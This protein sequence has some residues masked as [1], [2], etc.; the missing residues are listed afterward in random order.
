MPL[1]PG[2]VL[3]FSPA[4]TSGS[5]IATRA[6]ARRSK[7]YAPVAAAREIVAA[8]GDGSRQQLRQCRQGIL[9]RKLA[10][11][12]EHAGSVPGARNEAS[13]ERAWARWLAATQASPRHRR[14]LA[15]RASDQR[16]SLRRPVA[17]PAG[18]ARCPA[19][20]PATLP[21]ERR[22]A[23]PAA[24]RRRPSG[25]RCATAH[26]RR[27]LPT[28]R[29]SLA[30]GPRFAASPAARSPA[31]SAAPLR[32]RPPPRRRLRAKTSPPDWEARLQDAV[33]ARVTATRPSSARSCA[34]SRSNR[35]SAC[36]CV[37]S[38]ADALPRPHRKNQRTQG[39]IHPRK[40][41]HS[42]PRPIRNG[43][44]H[45]RSRDSGVTRQEGL[46]DGSIREREDRARAAYALRRR[47]QESVAPAAAAGHRRPPSETVTP[48]AE[49][50]FERPQRSRAAFRPP[51]VRRPPRSHPA[52]W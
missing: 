50:A 22:A 7:A 23:G 8:H 29:R 11:H 43:H 32:N 25:N 27:P 17:A 35:S 3:D 15:R 5:G 24:M 48:A 39:E 45:A 33:S 12:R 20:G 6:A 31:G 10:A 18:C 36:S 37:I 21:P 16:P 44:T 34:L 2:A 52:M 28:R 42:T 14:V 46:W 47:P 4:V 49:H 1:L 51:S 26:A 19:A 41:R 13:G 38:C 40:L 9:A 30:R